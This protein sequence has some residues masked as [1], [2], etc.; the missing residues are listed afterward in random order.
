MPN[1][2]P[3]FGEWMV[4]A[5]PVEMSFNWCTYQC[6][7]CFAN[8]NSPHRRADI[9]AITRFLSEYP[10]RKTLEARLY[11][12]GY[13][14]CVS[15]LVD[16]FAPSNY[17]EAL[18]VIRLMNDLGLPMQFQTRGTNNLR[19]RDELL[20][21]LDQPAVWYISVTMLDDELRKR[22]EPGAP[23]IDNR[24]SFIEELRRRG[25][26][27]V[28]GLNPLVREWCPE[29]NVLIDRA[30]DCGVEGAWLE[31]AHFHYKQIGNM[32]DEDRAIIGPDIL[33]RA[34]KRRADPADMQH[35]LDARAY[36]RSQ[37]LEV[38]SIGQGIRSGFWD[39][40]HETYP[41]ATFFTS[42]DFVNFCYQHDLE[43]VLIPF[44]LYAAFFEPHLPRGKYPIDSYVG[45]VAH[46]LWWEHS[47]P[48]QM[49]YRDLL[50]I[51]WQ[52]H[53]VKFSPARLPCF[54]Y[55]ARWDDGS[56]DGKPGW[57]VYVDEAGL[58]Y[59]TFK[60]VTDESVMPF[61]DYYTHVDLPAD[62]LGEVQLAETVAPLI[63]AA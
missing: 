61:K 55:A 24:F 30:I 27:V 26:R 48:A 62:E 35:F 15:N 7:Y 51:G 20:D 19:W 16:M 63:D 49:T 52:R 23:R 50:A 60:K 28:L 54:A 8:L 44:E 12:Q 36:A 17:Q 39:I 2:T 42:Q 33:K 43:D 6:R 5:I 22:I 31:R 13:A 56:T 3:Y 34:Q 47:V 46:H 32:S 10:Q 38:Y 59:L 29:P 45:A 57:I 18:P 37:G 14:T 25:H 53:D 41:G 1:P 4:S 11:Q 40:Y 9:K 21:S 58:P